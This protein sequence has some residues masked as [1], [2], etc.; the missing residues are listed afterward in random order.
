MSIYNEDELIAPTWINEKF[1]ETVLRSSENEKYIK[2]KE[3][4]LN[5]ACVKGDHYASVMFRCHVIYTTDNNSHDFKQKSLIIKTLP[6]EEGMKREMLMSTKL[7]LT[8]IEMYKTTLP[9]IEKILNEYGEPTKLSADLIYYSL[10]P[11]KVIVLED[12]CESDYNTIRCRY[13]SE[14]EVKAVYRKLAKL[15]AVSYMLG[16]SGEHEYVTKYQ[17]G[18]FSSTAIMSN[19]VIAKGSIKFMETLSNYPE[20]K[21]FLDKITIMQPDIISKCKNLYRS[22]EINND[23]Q[24][25]YVL[26]YGDFHMKNL[27]FKFNKEN[28]LEDLIMVDYQISCYAPSTIDLIYSQYMLLSPELRLRRQEFMLYY[29]EE[30]LR[31]LKKIQFKGMM[32]HYSDFQIAALK[33]RHFSIFLFSTFL[34]IVLNFMVSSASDLKDYD[35]AKLMENPKMMMETIY[36]NPDFINEIRRFMPVL[37]REGYLD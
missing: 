28:Q 33:Y 20:F 25:I 19:D 2:I 16:L 5:P 37:L 10:E 12:L 11:H 3:F 32:P 36:K 35:A 29:F 1:L 6:E 26:N 17:D 24:D 18:L 31:I 27:M 22:Y 30:F 34:P 4:T 15:H 7:F 9:K 13:L 21:V 8:E 14:S 23:P